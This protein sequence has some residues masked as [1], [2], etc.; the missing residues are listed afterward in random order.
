MREVFKISD[1]RNLCL[2]KKKKNDEFYTQL[3]DI[4]KELKHYKNH[5]VSKTV[6]CNCNDSEESNFW[7]Y[8]S[9]NFDKLKLK[10]LIATRFENGTPFFLRNAT[11]PVIGCVSKERVNKP[12]EKSSYRLEMYRDENGLHTDKKAL[13]QNGDFRSPECV[14]LL[15]EA[16]IVI[17]NPPF[18]LFR[19]YVAQLMEYNKQFLII[20]NKNAITYKEIFPLL[21]NNDIW[22]GYENVKEFK[23]PDGTIKKFGNI[24]WFTNLDIS[25][26]HEDII[27]YRTYNTTDY[28]KYDNYDAINVN[29]VSEIPVDYSGIMGV[30]ITFM[31]KYNPEQFEIIGFFNNF[32]PET[33][34][35]GFIYGDKV[36]VS[37]TTSKFRG[38]V[39]A[40]KAKYFRVIIKRKER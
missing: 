4:E 37:T 35:D 31:D 3:T 28:P 34:G 21:K 38:P 8:F 19:E 40:G 17:T 5:F 2:A 22:L 26:K 32:K 25:K 11:S 6:F 15:K 18:S 20:G 23:Q 36:S 30:P 16:D 33:A 27:L 29:K 12:K 1:H 10:K 39:V 14:E 7:K 9:L 24:G 13:K